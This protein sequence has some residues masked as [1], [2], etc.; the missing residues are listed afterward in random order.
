MKKENIKE[1]ANEL[2]EDNSFA[3]KGF[4]KGAEW[5]IN[6]VWHPITQPPE[7]NKIYVAQIGKDAF[8]TFYD[9]G[10]WKPFSKGLNFARWA[11][12]EDLIPTNE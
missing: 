1:K 11:Y 7:R 2:Y 6:S 10:N 3:Y 12:I 8:E 4:I 5:R 9:S